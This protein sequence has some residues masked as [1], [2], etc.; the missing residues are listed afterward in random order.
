MTRVSFPRALRRAVAPVAVLALLVMAPPG[1]AGAEEPG[2]DGGGEPST[3]L[4]RVDG[5]TILRVRGFAGLPAQERARAIEGRIV[6]LARSRA[7]PADALALEETARGT[8]VVAGTVTLL[9]VTDADAAL[10]ELS[11]Q[12]LAQAAREAIAESVEDWRAQRSSEKRLR[13][14]GWALGATLLLGI[15]LLVIGRVARRVR[16]FFATRIASRVRS[17]GVQSFEIVK[18]GHLAAVAH[19]VPRLGYWLA[20]AVSIY[21]YLDFVLALFPLTRPV[22]ERLMGL[23]TDPLQTLGL[24]LLSQLPNLAFLTVLVVVVRYVLKLMRLYFDAIERGVVRFERFDAEWAI[25]TYKV[26]RIFVV[27]FAL[28]IAYPY[29]PGSESAA[30][31]GVSVMLGVLFSLGSSSI[32]GNVIAGYSMTYRRAFRRGDR[33][34]VGAITGDVVESRVL[35]TTLRTPKNELVVVPNSE[36]LGSSIVNYSALARESGLILH[37]TV[38][39]GYETPWRQV[40]AMLLMAAGRTEGLK[41]EPAPFVLQTSLGDFCVTYELNACTDDPQQMARQYSALHANIL[42]VFNEYG[43]QIMTPAYEGDPPEPKI[44]RPDDLYAAPARPPPAPE[45]AA[46][47]PG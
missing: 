29:I 8:A 45:A 30:F 2:F 34:R 6:D 24:A 44:V 28:V 41:R 46:A 37:T 40:E 7:V 39:I 20:V 27:A 32:I 9:T 12:A 22:G 17:V 33:I 21:L 4:V 16:A 14:A 36:I 19:A 15:L 35:V 18:A 5:R 25:P 31:K 13:S 10:E 11:R 38:G 47:G 43:V 42:D 26:L 3:A 1:G 23:V